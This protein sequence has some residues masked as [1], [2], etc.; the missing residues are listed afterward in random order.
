MQSVKLGLAML[1]ALSTS[2][3]ASGPSIADAIVNLKELEGQW[4]WFTNP[5]ESPKWSGFLNIQ[6]IDDSSGRFEGTQTGND[7]KITNGQFTIAGGQVE[8]DRDVL[9][10]DANKSRFQ[11]WNGI[12]SYTFDLK[13]VTT[14]V[15]GLEVKIK[16][17]DLTSPVIQIDGRWSGAFDEYAKTEADR[18]F[19]ATKRRAPK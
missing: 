9:T 10:E 4:N 13:E 19:R 7:S 8:W 11:S 16:V 2:M 18:T 1:I 15:N 6:L 14:I 5:G 12:L 3:L 17:P